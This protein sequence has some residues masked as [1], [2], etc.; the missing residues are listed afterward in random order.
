MAYCQWLAEVTG[1]AYR[2]PSEAE[3]EK[4]ARGGL[5]VGGEANPNAGRIYP[6]GNE[7]EK[8]RCNSRG[9]WPGRYYAGGPVFTGGEIAPTVVWTWPATCGNGR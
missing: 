4:A 6:W 3:W 1:R 8:K 9:R 2:L 7:W 5:R